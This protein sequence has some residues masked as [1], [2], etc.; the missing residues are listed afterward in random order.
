MTS[1]CWVLY[2]QGFNGYYYEG[3]LCAETVELLPN[4]PGSTNPYTGESWTQYSVNGQPPDPMGGFRNGT[5]YVGIIYL[6]ILDQYCPNPRAAR[7][8]NCDACATLPP[9]EK[10]YDCINGIC[11]DKDQYGT[12]GIYSTLEECQAHCGTSTNSCE[13]PNICVSPDYCPPGMVCIPSSEW[14]QIEGLSSSIKDGAC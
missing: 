6:P 13:P 9:T 8:G 14:G 7:S 2:G 4:R 10:N 1:K 11:Y 3:I 12:P 5:A